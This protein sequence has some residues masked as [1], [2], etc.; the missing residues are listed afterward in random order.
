MTDL[1][2]S[3]LLIADDL[4]VV[5]RVE[6]AC[7]AVGRHYERMGLRDATARGGKLSGWGLV[8]VDGDQ[9]GNDDFEVLDEALREE[10]TLVGDRIVFF[11]SHVDEAKLERIREAGF[12]AL[13]RGR[14]WRELPR[15]VADLKV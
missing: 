5:A 10:P 14:F 15:I 9:V 13:P 7:E 11:V 8:V 2:S 12:A 6:A 1:A 3:V 4:N